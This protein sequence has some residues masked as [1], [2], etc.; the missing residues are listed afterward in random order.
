MPDVL[1]NDFRRQWT[2]TS[3]A[4]LAAVAR[5]GASGWYILGREVE[6]FEQALADVL[7]CRRVIGCGSGLDAIEIA[8]RAGGVKPGSKVL[9]TPL[10]AFATTL[11]IVRAGGVP[12]FVDVDEA[13]LIDIERSREALRK[14]PAI[15]AM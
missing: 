3:A 14:D 2:D 15:R 13:G 9:T 4:V 1:L 7:G 11:A 10:S 6:A 8:L 5:V 12:V